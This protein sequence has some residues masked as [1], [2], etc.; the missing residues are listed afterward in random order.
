MSKK[1]DASKWTRAGPPF[2]NLTTNHLISLGG[3]WQ[4]F[5]EESMGRALVRMEDGEVTRKAVSLL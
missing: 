4:G 3:V 5:F 1:G 2:G